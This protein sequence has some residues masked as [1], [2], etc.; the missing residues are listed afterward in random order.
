MYCPPCSRTL[1]E[2]HD[3]THIHV[4]LQ[5]EVMAKVREDQGITAFITTLR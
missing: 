3:L 4:L 5:C 1:T 2:A